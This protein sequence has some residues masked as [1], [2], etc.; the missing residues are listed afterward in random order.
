MKKKVF[1]VFS[2]LIVLSISLYIKSFYVSDKMFSE[3]SLN[4]PFC[5][6]KVID[7]QKYFENKNVIGLYNYKPLAKGHCLII[8]KRH[9]QKFDELNESEI[10]DIF[11]LIKKTNNSAQKIFGVQSYQIIQK[12]GKDVGQSVPHLHFHYIPNKQNGSIISYYSKFALYPLMKKL[13]KQQM[14]EMTFLMSQN[15][16]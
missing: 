16:E 5:N 2:I 3:N 8:P 7:Y 14:K 11:E 13:D 10:K 12:N 15:L 4:C 6:Q 1:V 9:V